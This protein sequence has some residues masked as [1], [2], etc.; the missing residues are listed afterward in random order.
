[1]KIN[2]IAIVF[3]TL[4]FSMSSF[5]LE[6]DFS[7]PIHVSSISQHAKMK[8]N[9]VIFLDDV[10]LTQGTIRLTGDKLTVLRGA[11]PNHE[12]M[13]TDGQ[14]ATF[15]QTQD[16]GKPFDAEANNIH[17]DVAK[18]KI[19]LTG[20]AQVK[21]LDSQINGAKIV[22]FLDSEELIVTTEIGEKER[23]KTVFLPAQ[24]EKNE[25]DATSEEEKK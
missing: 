10:L 1:M 5:S 9:I 16:D 15:Y 25:D 20:N 21:Q 4:L 6:S 12:I 19:I 13:I 3:S 23:V 18:S 11:E 17:Y 24:F 2:K 14:L 8:D 22:Y 7:K